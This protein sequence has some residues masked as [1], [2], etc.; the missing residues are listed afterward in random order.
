MI[1]F[2]L[3]RN[4]APFIAPLAPLIGIVVAMKVLSDKEIGR[5]LYSY[6]HGFMGEV[7][8]G[9]QLQQLPS[10]WRV[11]H[12]LDLD[13]ENVDHVAVGI[14]GVFCIEVKNYS[15][16]VD[17]RP[18]GLFTHG[19]RNDK[20]VR[21]AHRQARLLSELLGVPVTPLLVFAGGRLSGEAVGKLTVMRAS[22]LLPYLLC[23][24]ERRMEYAEARK[25]FDRL[26]SITK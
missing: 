15:G 17:A 7:Q 13:G 9:K 25:V 19:K 6:G 21:Q 1:A 10:P 20:V 18:N 16:R 24:R 11:F 4:S 14:A 8:V 2:L 12:D 23:Q 22:D 5:D 26:D 3:V